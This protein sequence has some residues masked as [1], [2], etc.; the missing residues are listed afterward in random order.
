MLRIVETCSAWNEWVWFAMPLRF[1]MRAGEGWKGRVR[2]HALLDAR[3]MRDISGSNA[4]DAIASQHRWCVIE[5]RS[6]QEFEAI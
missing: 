3:R 1:R 6:C 5:A 4:G 2:V